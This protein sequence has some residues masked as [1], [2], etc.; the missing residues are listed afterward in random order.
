MSK[1]HR[2]KG[3]PRVST[4]RRVRKLG[5]PVQAAQSLFRKN[6]WPLSQAPAS[7]QRKIPRSEQEHPE[8]GTPCCLPRILLGEMHRL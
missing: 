8:I 2:R 1:T 6:M 4:V 5:V 3:C 7:H